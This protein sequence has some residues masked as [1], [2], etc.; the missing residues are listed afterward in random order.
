MKLSGI[1]HDWPEKAG[2]K[3]SRPDGHQEYTFLHFTTEI[4]FEFEGKVVKARPGAC[5]FYSPTHPQQFYSEK[6]IIHNW[7]HA[8]RSFGELLEKYNIP[9]N[10]ILYP[11]NTSFISEIFRLIE[12]EFFSQ[13]DYK[14]EIINAYIEEFLIK[15]SRALETQTPLAVINRKEREKMQRVRQTVLSNPEKRW[16]VSEMASL[17]TLSSS[18]FHT[19]YKSLFGTSP[20]KDVIEVKIRYAKSL[21][22]SDERLTLPVV[23][24]KLGYNDQYHFIRQF[25]G[26]TGETPGSY[27]KRKG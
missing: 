8:S 20:L 5:I 11:N 16:T 21:L 13:N 10:V 3:I 27:R 1:H 9:L 4:N 7:L 19:V 12:Q 24:E 25:K 23:A 26:V 17:A 15:F 14:E 2:F 22:L 6:D 18:R